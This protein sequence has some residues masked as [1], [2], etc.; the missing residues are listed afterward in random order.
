MSN[1]GLLVL[2]EEKG[3]IELLSEISIV[4]D[5]SIELKPFN[6]LEDLKAYLEKNSKAIFISDIFLR[7]ENFEETCEVLKC[8]NADLQV[9]AALAKPSISHVK[10]LFRKGVNDVVEL[11]NN[12]TLE[13]A[14]RRCSSNINESGLL[15]RDENFLK[16]ISRLTVTGGWEFDIKANT[17]YWDDV[18]SQIHE[19]EDGYTPKV[20][21]AIDFYYGEDNKANI[22]KAFGACI[23]K[24]E[25]YDLE[26]QIRTYN[27]NVKWVRTLGKPVFENGE[28]VK[29]FGTFQD[30]T[31]SKLVEIES[32]QLK[33]QL[34]QIVNS[35]K[36]L[37]QQF[38]I[39]EKG[40][41]QLTFI[42]DSVESIYGLKKED[43]L[44]DGT[45]LEQI[46]H[47]DDREKTLETVINAIRNVRDYRIIFR[48]ISGSGQLK[49][50]ETIGNIKS[51]GKN[52]VINAFSWDIT[53][54]IIAEKDQQKLSLIASK[55][56]NSFIITDRWGVV[57]W[58]N[59]SFTKVT[60][61]K[62][63]EIIGKRPKDLLQGKDTSK[64][65]SKYLGECIK[66]GKSG[67]AEILNY[68]KKGDP[69]W[70]EIYLDPVYSE[71]GELSNFI[72]VET[73]ITT[74]KARQIEIE[75]SK[76]EL[77]ETL[78][79][80]RYQKYALDEHAIVA[81]TD[82]KGTITY[83]NQKFCEISGYDKSVLIGENHRILN[84]GY[85]PKSFFKDLYETIAN[86]KTWRNEIKNKRKDGSFYW[87]DTTI[88]PV[89]SLNNNKPERYIAIRADITS[90]KKYEELLI[91][92]N[93]RSQS[94][95]E[96]AKDAI[97][98]LDVAKGEIGVYQGY[99]ELFEID[100][101]IDK[102]KLEDATKFIHPDDLERVLKS[103]NDALADDLCILWQEKYRA[104]TRKNKV[105]II[106]DKAKIIR[107]N[108]GMPVRL[109]GAINDVTDVELY[110]EK[111]QKQNEKLKDIAWI[112]SHVVR[113]P[114]ANLLGLT[115]LFRMLQSDKEAMTEIVKNIENSTLELDKVVREVT[116]K[117][118]EL[119]NELKE[120]GIDD[121][122][123]KP[124]IIQE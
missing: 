5:G 77:E 67:F 87:V 26:L 38:V 78:H 72:A 102:I 106:E 116:R 122:G 93:E 123:S 111:I 31:K 22:L 10:E 92:S 80:L 98:E 34:T 41:G 99:S 57:E 14:L 46:I 110:I 35:I 42:D 120:D 66:E 63:S 32:S 25:M 56:T 70:I 86:G 69:Y 52:I 43:I 30:I 48:I 2:N 50:I 17:L 9:I 115:N 27:G 74:R 40:N 54:R 81:I 37:V 64:E 104:V 23:S 88:V 84:S 97:W 45:L 76:K 28:C 91:E 8:C 103:L 71:N 19:V 18:T 75:K 114:L 95:I 47:D 105:L 124:S 90:R 65:A 21:E 60:G 62:A 15:H 68:T 96:I 108:E 58:V 55:S 121:K 101:D 117:S 119:Y 24:G 82:V 12:D 13:K 1:L 51:V 3:L 112:Q 79:E 94:A 73:D 83:V 7:P 59:D 113:A 61:Y 107:N 4:N 36:G 49:W 89:M 6:S 20:D 109:M 29:V 16:E 53:A 39:D 100:E 85:H 44:N 11:G 33:E 118:E